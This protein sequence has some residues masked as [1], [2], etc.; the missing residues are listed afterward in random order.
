MPSV[1]KRLCRYR[2]E[3][4]RVNRRTEVG[5]N[6]GL[7][8]SETHQRQ[9]VTFRFTVS[10]LV[11]PAPEQHERGPEEGMRLGLERLKLRLS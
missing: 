8:R 5:Q 10:L 6:R 9:G 1:A 3:T 2:K 11:L 4:R 7:I